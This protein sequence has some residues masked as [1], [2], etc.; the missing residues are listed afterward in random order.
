MFRPSYPLLAVVIAAAAGVIALVP[1]AVDRSDMIG[2]LRATDHGRRSTTTSSDRPEHP[3]LHRW[4]NEAPT[5]G[6]TD[7]GGQIEMTVPENAGAAA[8]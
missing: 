2:Y 5:L 3:Q 6:P 7:A 8:R 1:G 4:M